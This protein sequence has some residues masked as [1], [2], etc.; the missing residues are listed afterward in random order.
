MKWAVPIWTLLL[1]HYRV[2]SSVHEQGKTT[3][4]WIFPSVVLEVINKAIL[5]LPS[6]SQRAM[7]FL[8][9]KANSKKKEVSGQT[10]LEGAQCMGKIEVTL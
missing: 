7:I 1:F 2:G 4:D 10:C 9:I 5:K 3:P 6:A 8:D